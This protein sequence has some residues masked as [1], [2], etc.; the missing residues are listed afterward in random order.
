MNKST[1]KHLPRVNQ[2]SKKNLVTQKMIL[3]KRF[4]IKLLKNAASCLLSSIV[5]ISILG[6]PKKSVAQNVNERPGFL[7]VMRLNKNHEFLLIRR[8]PTIVE[9]VKFSIQS[10]NNMEFEPDLL[11]NVVLQLEYLSKPGEG[12]F[13]KDLF[14]TTIVELDRCGENGWCR[15]KRIIYSETKLKEEENDGKIYKDI[16]YGEYSEYKE[17][18]RFSTW[19][20]SSNF[21]DMNGNSIPLINCSGETTEMVRANNLVKGYQILKR[22]R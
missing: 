5:A 6:I 13:A 9:K 3:S 4:K 15:L 19:V 12:A 1:Y 10:L 22:T 17:D 7:A 2:E 14:P 11:K 20:P 8:E 18:S 21:C 16:L